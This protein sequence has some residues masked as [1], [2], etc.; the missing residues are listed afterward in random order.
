MDDDLERVNR[1]LDDLAA[2]RDPRD[3]ADLL[4]NEVMLAETAAWLKVAGGTRA[5]PSAEFIDRLGARVAA[6]TAHSAR[7]EA[8]SASPSEPAT[9]ATAPAGPSRRGLLSRLIVGVAGLTLGAGTGAAAAYERGKHDGARQEAGESFR[10]PLV[11][12]DR[13]QW[14]DTGQTLASIA[15]GEAVRF[16]VGALEG[17]LVNPGQGR[18]VYA[19]SAA[20][21]HMGCLLTWLSA[22]GG[23]LC[24]CHGARYNLDGTVHSGIARHP[25]PRLRVHVDRAGRLFIWGVTAHPAITTPVP[26]SEP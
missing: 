19:V 2:E 7:P 26:Y 20:C 10:T 18:P 17:F 4:A 22:S 1:V 25:L 16:H 15:P 24:P 11:P 5:T 13:G 8:A 6:A 21:T 9:A 23:F 3:R 14:L 12:R